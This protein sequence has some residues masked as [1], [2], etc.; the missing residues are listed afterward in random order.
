MFLSRI[1]SN[2][3]KLN[4]SAYQQII[5]CLV[6]FLNQYDKAEEEKKEQEKKKTQLAELEDNFKVCNLIWTR[7]TSLKNSFSYMKYIKQTITFKLYM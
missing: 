4:M 2:K 7:Y 1:V 6:K 3:R 5:K